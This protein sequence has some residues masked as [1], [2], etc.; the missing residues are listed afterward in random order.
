MAAFAVLAADWH[1]ESVFAGP[2][3]GA[4]SRPFLPCGHMGELGGALC[5]SIAHP[6]FTSPG[7]EPGVLFQR[8]KK[9]TPVKPGQ[10]EGWGMPRSS[11][12]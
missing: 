10:G 1:R 7:I 5:T 4:S 2:G 3:A 11:R 9:D 6:A 12:W 8:P